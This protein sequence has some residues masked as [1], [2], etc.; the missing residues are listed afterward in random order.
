[1]PAPPPNGVSSTCPP[2]SGVWSR[3]LISRRREP[4]A[5]ALRTCR[6]LSNQSNHSGNSVKMSIST[7]ARPRRLI[8]CAAPRRGRLRGGLF[9]EARVDLDPPLAHAHAPHRIFYERHEQL[10][11]AAGAPHLE[12][13][14]GGKLEQP[15][16]RAHEPLTVAHLAP[17]QF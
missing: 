5:S 6:W 9:Q 15:R 7:S 16:H 1:M 14:T 12:C 11:L 13:L 17:L 2:V 3:K 4:A 10:P 8:A